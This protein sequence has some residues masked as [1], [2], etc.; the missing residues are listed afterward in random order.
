MIVRRLDGQAT[1]DQRRELEE[2]LTHSGAARQLLAEYERN[3]RLAAEAIEDLVGGPIRIINP[4]PV[5]RSRRIAAWLA[6]GA[7]AA[8]VAM[9]CLW[10]VDRLMDSGGESQGSG[11]VATRGETESSRTSVAK[12]NQRYFAIYDEQH[13]E[14]HL[15]TP[16]AVQ[17]RYVASIG[18][19]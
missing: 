18:D 15:F 7:A 5:R 4:L 10:P 19:L 9:L 3:D 16:Q 14:L 8:A 1:A 2:I 13:G 12:D 6:W 17:A 11:P